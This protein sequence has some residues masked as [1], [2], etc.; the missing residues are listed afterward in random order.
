MRFSS[1]AATAARRDTQ[2]LGDE[3]RDE[4]EAAEGHARA[5]GSA[6]G[7]GAVGLYEERWLQVQQNVSGY[8]ISFCF[9]CA[10]ASEEQVAFT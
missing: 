6:R 1:A 2:R 10:C 9:Q 5:Q 8:T 7:G 3:A 4:A